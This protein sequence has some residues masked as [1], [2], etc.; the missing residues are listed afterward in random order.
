M[1][2]QTLHA[3]TLGVRAED[4]RSAEVGEHSAAIYA[5]SSFAFQSAEEAAA[6]FSGEENGF[7][8]SRFT[9]PT[10]KAF[11]DRLAAMEGGTHCVATASG[12][13][14][15]LSVC[16]ALLKT[17]DRIVAAKGLFG[18]TTGFLKNHLARFGVEVELV[19][20]SDLHAW[21]S[22]ISANTRM[23][24]AES[25]TNP[26]A[27][28]IDIA[29]LSQLANR[30]GIKLVVDNCFC[31]PALQKP[32]QLGAH[33][34]VHSATKFL[35]GQGRCVGGAVIGDAESV[36]DKV[37]GFMRSAGPCMSPFN[38]W[39]FLK[40]L[41]T[42]DLRMRA[43]SASAMKIAA[44]LEQHPA[45]SRVYYTG[46]P[47]HPQHELA[48][49]QQSAHGAIVGFDI[50]GGQS[51][52]FRVINATQLM[53]ITANLGDTRTTITHPASTTHFRIGAEARAEAGI[54]DG[55][56]RLSVGLEHVD[57]LIADL[58]QALAALNSGA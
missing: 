37:F 49:Q 43:H 16:M 55:L 22:A 1:S 6:R 3:Q 17:G 11:E 7:I 14:A 48:N 47:T 2:K 36:G 33:I 8:Y 19:D 28:V 58:D 56:L 25:P 39:V 44:W 31:T 35:D 51:E 54:G 30:H 42:L 27:T 10:I 50:H 57:D 20:A 24:F 34:V 12:M 26:L 40:G 4:W 41:E 21:E 5:T 53:T 32:L 29:A 45:V 9:N 15:I 46:L 13:A 23:F 38:A 52:A 18:S